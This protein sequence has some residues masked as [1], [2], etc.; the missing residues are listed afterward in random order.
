ML[1]GLMRCVSL[2]TILVGGNSNCGGCMWLCSG[3]PPPSRVPCEKRPA[4]FLLLRPSYA[5]AMPSLR[6]DVHLP[7]DVATCF[8][9]TDRNNCRR[10]AFSPD[11]CWFFHFKLAA[12]GEEEMKICTFV[13]YVP[14]IIA[15]LRYDGGHCQFASLH[16]RITDTRMHEYQCSQLG[17]IHA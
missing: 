15:D 8:S 2:R 13:W 12:D 9:N 7:R 16:H 10:L 1:T 3:T 17:R 14:L 6:P 4:W 5:L 11:I